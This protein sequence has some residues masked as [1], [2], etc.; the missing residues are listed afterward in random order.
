MVVRTAKDQSLKKYGEDL[1]ELG[2]YSLSEFYKSVKAMRLQ[3]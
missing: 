1:I 2:T 3:D